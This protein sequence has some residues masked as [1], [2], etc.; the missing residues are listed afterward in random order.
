MKG[1]QQPAK[2]TATKKRATTKSTRKGKR[3]KVD[4]DVKESNLRSGG[5]NTTENDSYTIES[6]TLN[7]VLR[8]RGERLEDNGAGG[9]CYYRCIAASRGRCPD[10]GHKEERAKVVKCIGD[11]ESRFEHLVVGEVR[12]VK[13][14]RRIKTLK[15]YLGY[16]RK[17]C[18]SNDFAYS[19][20]KLILLF[21]FLM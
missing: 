17:V 15:Q 13:G 4:D 9:N 12:V 5:A 11:N 20:C 18:I 1:A 8:G 7:A 2:T 6:T 3:A 16:I 21:L 10:S 14:H 19:H